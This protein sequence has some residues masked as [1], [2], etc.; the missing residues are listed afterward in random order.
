MVRCT[1]CGATR[2]M[3]EA[4]GEQGKESL[5]AC[6]GYHP[7]LQHFE[8]GCKESLRPVLLGASNS[9][10]PVALS[11][12][13][14][15][16]EG[17]ELAQLVK[18]HWGLLSRIEDKGQ[19]GF[20]LDMV[21]ESGAVPA[22]SK[23]SKDAIWQAIDKRR[24]IEEEEE[25][26]VVDLKD[27]EWEILT[28]EKPLTDW[29]DFSARRVE[30]LDELSDRINSV[31]LVDRLREV[32]A[33]VGLTRVE[34]PE[35]GTAGSAPPPRAPIGL[36]PP[37]WVPAT[38]VR[39]EGI[40]IEF[41]PAA[42]A[43]WQASAGVVK[44]IAELAAG[45]RDWRAARRIEPYDANFP[46]GVYALVHTFSHILLRELALECGYNAASIRERIYASEPGDSELRAGLLLYTAAADS[47]GTLGG[48][49]ELGKPENLGRLIQ[50]GLDRAT[51][52]AS[53]PLCGEHIASNDGTLHGAACHACSFV[54][55]TS[56]EKGNRYLDRRLLVPVIGSADTAFFSEGRA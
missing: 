56:C 22:L 14:I 48:L 13:A 26:G 32:K 3:V 40:F 16:T 21:K 38:E 44:R 1:D 12:L 5:P 15:P 18:D 31:R 55:E 30:A 25:D 39:G 41:E 53:D 37:K 36:N 51:V 42:I 45:H 46:G 4:F 19:L 50:Q 23:Y 17:D 49:V 52:C 24:S 29:P 8:E 35:E 10:F 20:G 7:H 47:A 34:P 54:S 27:L 43:K 11:A 2:S 6:R 28:A 33:M 9:W